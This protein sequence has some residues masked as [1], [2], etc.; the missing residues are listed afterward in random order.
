VRHTFRYLVEAPAGPGATVTL[1]PADSHHLL[2]VVR[3]RAGDPLELIDGTGL[4]WPAVL[5]E[6]GPPAAVRV[7]A[8]RSAAR[9]APVALYQGLADWGRLDVVVEKAAELG[10]E[11]VTLFTSAR[12][13][14]VPAEDAWR[15]RRARL[16]RV[17]EAA[18][19]QAG[20]GHLPRLDGLVSF[21][22]A[23]GEI[24]A[25][26]AC[27]LDPA[28]EIP[29]GAALGRIASAGRATL[30]IGPEAGFAPEELDAAR[31]AGLPA[32]RL[33][34]EIL[35]A[36]TAA[37]VAISLALGAVGRFAS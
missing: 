26:G 11:R 14:R 15:R 12:V 4:L 20:Q 5:V 6:E 17:A 1:S 34:P 10:L 27:L 7:E 28:G 32:C 3:R 13:R 29:I 33:G 36:E 21:E 25:A 18:A 35:R 16:V 30:I 9:P 37:L 8:P 23:L 22:T 24:P 31:A 19:R 2:R